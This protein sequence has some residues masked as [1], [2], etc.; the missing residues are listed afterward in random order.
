MLLRLDA[1]PSGQ[2]FD[3]RFFLYYEDEDLSRRLFDA[4]L[5]VVLEPAV[6]VLHVHR[7]SVRGSRPLQ[8]DLALRARL[9]ALD[10]CTEDAI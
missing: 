9:A 8:V 10:A 5:P 7:G 4:H 3:E 6:R 2:W 1:L